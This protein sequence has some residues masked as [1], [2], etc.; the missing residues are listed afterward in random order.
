LL[1]LLLFLLSFP[2]FT[3]IPQAKQQHQNVHR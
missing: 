3:K 2:T 1:L